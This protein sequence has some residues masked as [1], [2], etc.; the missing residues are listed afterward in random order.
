L[1]IFALSPHG[2]SPPDPGKVI[3]VANSFSDPDLAVG[4]IPDVVA[5]GKTL[6]KES[7]VKEWTSERCLSIKAAEKAWDRSKFA[8][9]PI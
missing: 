8:P 5:Q 2:K 1:A 6:P 7:V 3:R 4:K 9:S